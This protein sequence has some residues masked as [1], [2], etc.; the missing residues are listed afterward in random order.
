MT[1]NKLLDILKTTKRWVVSADMRDALVS[2]RKK[3]GLKQKDVV[4][5]LKKELDIEI[6]ASYYGM[7]EQDVRTPGLELAEA[8]SSLFGMTINEVFFAQFPNNLLGKEVI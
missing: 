2:L 6:T 7:I 4:L 3:N 8:I 1:P 5:R